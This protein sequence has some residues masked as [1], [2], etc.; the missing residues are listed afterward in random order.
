MMNGTFRSVSGEFYQL[1]TLK[2]LF[3]GKYSTLAVILKKSKDEDSYQ[4]IFQKLKLNFR[5]QFDFVMV[6]F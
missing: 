2:G 5:F 3:L 1:L 6:D 4:Q